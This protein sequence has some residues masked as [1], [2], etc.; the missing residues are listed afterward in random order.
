M[1]LWFNRSPPKV[2]ID[3]TLNFHASKTFGFE[4]QAMP[5]RR[6]D[7]AIDTGLIRCRQW[8]S[9]RGVRD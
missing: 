9:R 3:R 5:D 7:D 6:G 1:I 8:V 4:L 2:A